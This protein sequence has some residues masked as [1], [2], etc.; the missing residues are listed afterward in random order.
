MKNHQIFG[1]AILLVG[2]TSNLW[3]HCEVPCGIY[4]DQLRFEKM[5]EDQ[6][7]ISKAITSIIELA[8]KDDA[9]S[10]NQLARWVAT[11]EQ[12][13]TAVQHAISQYFMS[14]RLMEDHGG[15][16][17]KLTSAHAVMVA[18]MKCKQSTDIDAGD[19]LRESILEFHR[20]YTGKNDPPT[21]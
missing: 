12:H 15:Y 13:A 1:I 9:L 17:E 8:S 10:R 11:K 16:V 20:I 14:Q 7:T 3:A 19:R 18:A 21:G 6:R 2:W 5:L 4:G